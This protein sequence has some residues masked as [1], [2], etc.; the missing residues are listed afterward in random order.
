LRFGRDAGAPAAKRDLR[1]G[2]P[3][4]VSHTQ[5]ALSLCPAEARLAGVDEALGGPERTLR[6]G[7]PVRRA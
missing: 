5:G 3:A 7:L 6:A 1:V 4:R 2:R